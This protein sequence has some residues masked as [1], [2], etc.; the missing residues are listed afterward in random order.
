MGSE[1]DIRPDDEFR[2]RLLA[3]R[4]VGWQGGYVVGIAGWYRLIDDLIDEVRREALRD[5]I[6]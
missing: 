2:R 4:N 5:S 1:Q 6:S 3:V